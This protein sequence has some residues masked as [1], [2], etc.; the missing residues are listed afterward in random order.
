MTTSTTA[1]KRPTTADAVSA[2]GRDYRLAGLLLMGMGPG[3]SITVSGGTIG[4][5]LAENGFSPSQ[6]G[7]LG[8]SMLPFV[9][10][11]IW[12]PLLEGAFKPLQN[13]L[14]FRRSWLIPLNFLTVA[15]ILFLSQSNPAGGQLGM[16]AAACFIF[17][18][19]AASQ[20]VVIEGLRI[21][22]T[23][24]PGMPIGATIIGIGARLG[25]LIGS[26]GPLII[27]T[28]YGWPTALMF[29]AG[30]MSLV[31]VGALIFGEG[32]PIDADAQPVALKAR[33][34]D[35]FREFFA[36]AG[37]PLVFAFV[38]AHRLGDS[39]AGAMFPP[40]AVA[41]KFTKDQVAFAS[42]VVG[43]L[44][45]IVGSAVGLLIYRK[46]SERSGLLTA[47]IVMAVSNI[48]FVVLAGFQGNVTALAIV[49]GFENFAGGVGGVIVLSYL[50][51]LC[52]A[53]FTA[54][55][56]A[57]LAAASAVMRIVS[58]GP[59]G[60]LVEAIGYQSFFLVTVA[61]FLPAIILLLMMFRRD[62]VSRKKASPARADASPLE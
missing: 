43:F 9:L 48:G 15:A 55:Q 35:P 25:I 32:R 37:G 7:F 40:F 4:F 3:L 1:P 38:L 60:K 51:R 22:R 58:G 19:F 5:W 57:L 50:S 12:A 23:R 44:A 54:T 8:L 6:I 52:N 49:M 10:K 42:S 53:R 11:F 36:R 33:L 45:L 17:S 34:I 31:S 29:V 59:S 28:R 13:I 39:M 20:E 27:A 26:A 47:L 56:F 61:A 2:V 21:D 30:A 46:F 18:I 24:G 14:G 62:L 41:A 16:I